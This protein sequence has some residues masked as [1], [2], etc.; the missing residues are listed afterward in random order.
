MYLYSRTEDYIQHLLAKINIKIP[1]ELRIENISNSL[2]IPVYF[3]EFSSET[4]YKNGKCIIF[5]N[6]TNNEQVQWQEFAHEIAHNLWHAGRQEYL[7]QAFIELQEWQANYFSY[8]LCV[9][10][11]MLQ[12]IPK[13]S[14]Y[15]IMHLFNVE[16]EFAC[17][18]LEMYK[19]KFI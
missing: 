3:W 6:A 1:T 18:R 9:P 16:Y 4:V 17:K 5:L 15:Q 8:H 10:T 12:R 2:K 19:N 11:F 13:A 7:P 14:P